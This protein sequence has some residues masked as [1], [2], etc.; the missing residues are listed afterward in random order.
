MRGA[1]IIAAILLEQGVDTIFGYPGVSNLPLYDALY[2]KRDQLR[3]VLL[4]HEQHAAHAADGYARTTGKTGVVIAT[5]GPGA[6]NLV[7]G[8]AAA[9]MDSS[10]VVAITCNVP[11]AALGKDSFQ[12]VDIAGI[13]MPVT[14]HNV[15]V[16]R[17]EDIAPVLRRAFMIANTGRKGPVLVDITTDATLACAKFVQQ[18]PKACP[19][20]FAATEAALKRAADLVNQ[21]ERPVILAGGGAKQAKEELQMLS[22]RLDAPVVLS[23][24]GLGAFPVNHDHFYGMLGLF[25]DDAARM[26]VTQADAV[27]AVGTRFSDR[28]VPDPHLFVGKKVLHIDIDPAE[29]NKNI[30]TDAHLDADAA[31]ALRALLPLLAKKEQTMPE[32]AQERP[33]IPALAA[34]VLHALRAHCGEDQIYTTD[35]GEHQMW[36]AKLLRT[37]MPGKF[38]TSGGLGAMGFGLGA[39]V[40]AAVGTGRSVVNLTGDGSFYMNMAELSTVARL[41]L[42]VVDVVFNNAQLG[43]VRRWQIKQ[44][45]GR[46]YESDYQRKT[47]IPA[48]AKAFAVRGYSI[49]SPQ[50][51]GVLNEALKH[52]PAVVEVVLK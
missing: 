2:E 13:S 32:K 6:T 29:I 46:V 30:A 33:E 52:A 14:K 5:S 34:D 25:G 1:Q 38:I 15:I 36:A 40:G 39:A 37:S 31:P 21:S 17:V 51:I 4:T 42:P 49:A 43:M 44:F 10:P 28:C 22:Q 7:T 19:P 45:Q 8:I 48:L 3:H 11:S 27:I 35:V 24:M 41:S 23:L 16:K 47:D 50:D 18:A 26:A 12:E 20:I 9:Y